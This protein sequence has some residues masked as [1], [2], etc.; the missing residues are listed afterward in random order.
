M[1]PAEHILCNKWHPQFQ[2]PNSSPD[3]LWAF[4]VWTKNFSNFVS[5]IWKFNNPYYHTLSDVK[6]EIVVKSDI[7]PVDDISVKEEPDNHLETLG[8]LETLEETL[9]FDNDDWIESDEPLQPKKRKKRKL[10]KV[11][12]EG[13]YSMAVRV[14]EFS[15]GGYKIRKIFA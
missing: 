10:K 2:I 15:N 9:Y 8:T 11:K 5:L 7:L 14:V 1:A 6:E 13:M 3:S 4:W 12:L